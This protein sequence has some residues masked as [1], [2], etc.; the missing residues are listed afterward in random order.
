[1]RAREGEAPDA[2]RGEEY[3]EWI[4]RASPARDGGGGDDDGSRDE[5]AGT[6]K[7]TTSGLA[8]PA[9]A[10][11]AVAVACDEMIRK[12][13]PDGVTAAVKKRLANARKDII[14]ITDVAGARTITSADDDAFV[15]TLL[16]GM[17]AQNIRLRVG[18]LDDANNAGL[19]LLRD[20]TRRLAGEDASNESDVTSAMDLLQ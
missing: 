8:P 11:E 9:D 12:Y 20:I 5:R 18:I 1:M 6:S 3:R 13:S 10:A 19:A 16:E 2:S 15:S 7:D 14:L 4:V 17:S